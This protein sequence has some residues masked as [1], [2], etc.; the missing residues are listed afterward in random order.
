MGGWSDEWMSYKSVNYVWIVV[1][2]FRQL[3]LAI[4]TFKPPTQF[5]LFHSTRMFFVNGFWKMQQLINILSVPSTSAT[6]GTSKN[7]IKQRRETCAS[8]WMEKLTDFNCE[9]WRLQTV[10]I[11]N[12]FEIISTPIKCWCFHFFASSV[13]AIH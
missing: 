4:K 7:C 11:F 6:A 12:P 9:G 13:K 3:K 1:Q 8:V 2:I 5:I 10:C